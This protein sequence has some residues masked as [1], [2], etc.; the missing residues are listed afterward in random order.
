MSE[1]LAPYIEH[2]LLKPEAS[3]DDIIKLCREAVEHS[4][5]AVCINPCF[6]QKACEQL[7]ES[8]IKVCTVIGFPLGAATTAVKAFE[9]SDAV[10]NGADELDMVIN[11]GAVKERAREY[12][13]HDINSVT[14]ASR[15]RPVKV[16]L[17]TALLDDD[18]KVWASRLAKE[19]GASFIKTST[20]F[21]SAG[22]CTGDIR[23]LRE[24]VGPGVGIKASGGM[25]TRRDAREMIDA[26]ASRIGTSNGIS[27]ITRG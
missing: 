14:G 15:G 27:I 16:I 23:L 10:K 7:K 8:G 5:Y 13:F 26:G 1:D 17:E 4:F 6:V 18:E 22:A 2:T 9:A 11:I 24:T 12:V 25:R 21:Y 20:G 19:A 3:A